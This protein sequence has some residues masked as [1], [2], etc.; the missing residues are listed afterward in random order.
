MRLSVLVAEDDVV[1]ALS[2]KQILEQ[3]GHQVVGLARDGQE[4]CEM[5]QALAPDLVVLDLR[6]PRMD[7]LAAATLIKQKQP[8]P[9]VAVTAHADQDLLDRACQAGIHGYLV[10]PVD[11]DCLPQ[12]LELAYANFHRLRDLENQVVDLREQLRVRKLMERAKGFLMEKRGF[13]EQEAA[14]HLKLRSQAKNLPL[15]EVAESLVASQDIL[16]DLEGE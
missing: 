9:M 2:F 12:A 3:A 8:L 15:V 4:A 1:Q 13:S 11:Q 16:G 5:S 7:G 10:K 6:M 14:S